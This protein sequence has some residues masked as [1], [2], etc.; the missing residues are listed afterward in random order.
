MLK[1]RIKGLWD[2]ITKSLLLIINADDDVDGDHLKSSTQCVEKGAKK[3]FR[4][5]NKEFAFDNASQY[6]KIDG[7]VDGDGDHDGRDGDGDGDG[8]GDALLMV[9]SSKLASPASP[10]P[11]PPLPI[12]ASNH[13]LASHLTLTLHHANLPSLGK[14]SE[15]GKT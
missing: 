10:L 3:T 7:D 14:I 4:C 12:Q 11:Y 1:K 6:D 8:D 13:H 15:S 9:G 5:V 2:G